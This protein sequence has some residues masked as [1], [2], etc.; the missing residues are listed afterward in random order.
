MTSLG[1]TELSVRSRG[2]ASSSLPARNSSL[3]GPAHTSYEQD[4]GAT[5]ENEE[6]RKL[7]EQQNGGAAAAASVVGQ[8]PA[9]SS[10]ASTAGGIMGL[11][12]AET[13]IVL[14]VTA[15]AAIVRL[16]KLSQPS[17]VV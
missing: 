15:V 10:V 1:Q 14:G 12:A 6:S 8:N 13:R 2:G 11:G 3:A 5:Y 4:D 7:L 9:G 16:W 17:S